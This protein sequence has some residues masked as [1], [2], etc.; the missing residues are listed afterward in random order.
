MRRQ[1]R[2][3]LVF[4]PLSIAPPDL[5]VC[6]LSSCL[7][8]CYPSTQ[9][10]ASLTAPP[11]TYPFD[12]QKPKTRDSHNRWVKSNIVQH[13]TPHLRTLSVPTHFCSHY[14]FVITIIPTTTIIEICRAPGR[15][16]TADRMWTVQRYE[17]SRSG[18][19]QRH[20]TCLDERLHETSH[21]ISLSL[22]V[23]YSFLCLSLHVM[24]A[25]I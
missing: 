6:R 4:I 11:S 16:R 3:D 22:S 18:S 7:S 10:S 9:H 25:L 12:L 1:Q 14:S 2:K 20:C 23:L 15:V 8:V 24:S 17:Q 5:C 13:K 21:L 19:I